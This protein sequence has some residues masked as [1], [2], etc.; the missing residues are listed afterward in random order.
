M[1]RLATEKWLQ[2]HFYFNLMASAAAAIA[3]TV[4]RSTP[5][6]WPKIHVSML[7][8]LNTRQ[9]TQLLI[10]L[11]NR[12]HNSITTFYKSKSIDGFV[13]FSFFSSVRVCV[14]VWICMWFLLGLWKNPIGNL[15]WWNVK[16]EMFNKY[17]TKLTT[18]ARKQLRNQS[19][20]THKSKQSEEKK[21]QTKIQ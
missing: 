20:R 7:S 8:T 9:I 14:F 4:F 18:A 17:H 11:A 21:Q 6:E 5:L 19:I 12:N 10:N 2:Q 1:Y 16:W 3:A 13:H 15:T